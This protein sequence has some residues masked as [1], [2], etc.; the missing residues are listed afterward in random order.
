MSTGVVI[1]G[2]S[3]RELLVKDPAVY[4]VPVV[5]N[6]ESSYIFP[7]SIRRFMI[8]A[9]A[10]AKLQIA[11]TALATNTTYFTLAPGAIFV[12]ENLD[13]EITV[14]FRSPQADVVEILTWSKV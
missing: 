11:F 1:P 5:A 7:N 13:K 12:E 10:G 4:N 6:T 14:F 2:S 9:R 3:S 8:K